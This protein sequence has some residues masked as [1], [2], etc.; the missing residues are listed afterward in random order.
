MDNRLK[1]VTNYNGDVVFVGTHRECNK[2]L[3]AKYPVASYDIRGTK[4]GAFLPGGPF[5]IQLVEEKVTNG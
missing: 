3:L 1:A 2:W 4:N 5:R